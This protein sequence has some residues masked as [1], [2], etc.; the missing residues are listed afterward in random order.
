MSMSKID[1][2][3]TTELRRFLINQMKGVSSGTVDPKR[4]KIV[5]NLSQQVYNTIRAEITAAKVA[6][7]NE[8][9]SVSIKSLKL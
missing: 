2:D 3:S 8:D 9:G 4:A 5:C 1:I 6:T 7:E